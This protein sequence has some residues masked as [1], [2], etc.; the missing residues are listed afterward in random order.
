M[1]V[2]KVVF[3]INPI[4]GAGRGK[5]TVKY[6]SEVFNST[7]IPY[8]IVFSEY[9]GHANQLAQQ[10]AKK[11][12][13]LIVAIGGDGT[14]NEVA[15]AL[16]G[17]RVALGIVPLGSGN[18][19]ARHLG[20]PLDYKKAIARLLHYNI[21]RIDAALINNRYFFCTS[22]LGFDA[23]V[24]M[25]FAQEGSRGFSTYV[26]AVIQ[27]LSRFKPTLYKLKVDGHKYKE[28]AFLIS[29]ANAAQYGNNA[30]IAPHANITDGM[31]D[32]S[33]I[34][35]FPP[36]QVFV[37]GFK[38]FTRK[39]DR[40]KYLKTYRGTKIVVKRKREGAVHIDGDPY[41]MGKKIKIRVAHKQLLVVT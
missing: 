29:F 18:G 31:V 13:K 17:T 35:P 11:N 10:Y 41:K 7:G 28:K 16:V 27:E 19:L 39:I 9:A 21:T 34:K 4:A 36:L 12:T 22:G 1:S 3:I 40:S 26:K 38:L 24:G 33:L 5:K 25:A 32:V 37:L 23:R 2:R 14:I 15:N 6:I 8:K 20:I 30:Y